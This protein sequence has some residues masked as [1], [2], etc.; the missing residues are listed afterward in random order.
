MT[1]H[2]ILGGNGFI[3][4]HVALALHRRGETVILADVTDPSPALLELLPVKHR[5]VTTLNPDWEEV[6][7]GAD[8][9]HHYAWTTI[10]SSADADPLVDFDSNL[11]ETIRLLEVLKKRKQAGG[12]GTKVVFSSSGGTIYGP[13]R[14]TPVTEIEPYDPIN[15]YGASKSAAEVYLKYYRKAHG[16]D[17]RIARISNPYGAGQNPAKRQGAASTFLFQALDAKPIS[18]WGDGEVVR[19]Y[20]HIADLTAAL[21]ALSDA[22]HKAINEAQSP[23]FNIGSGEGISLNRILDVLRT[24]LCLSPSVSYQTARSFDVPVSILDISKACRILE[25]KPK[26]SFEEGYSLMLADVR[27]GSALFSTLLDSLPQ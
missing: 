9:V 6:L 15:A 23:V 10:P 27:G 14:R 19:D 21:L 22:S 11:R 5:K 3:G 13:V 20:I 2:L 4:R 7:E 8:V 18:I 12:L 26:L 25:W 16:I 24:Q 17:C 1:V